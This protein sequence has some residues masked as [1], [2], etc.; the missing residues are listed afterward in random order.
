MRLICKNSTC[1]TSIW[2]N[3]FIPLSISNLNFFD[4]DVYPTFCDKTCEQRKNISKIP[5]LAQV[6]IKYSNK[7]LWKQIFDIFQYVHDAI[8]AKLLQSSV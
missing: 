4:T 3:R 5:F 2:L 1:I 7:Y 8:F 6:K